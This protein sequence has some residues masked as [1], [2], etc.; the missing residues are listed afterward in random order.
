MDH[1]HPLVRG[2]IRHG[3]HPLLNMA[4]ANAI[5]VKDPAN[6]LKLDKAQST[7]RIDPL[8]ATVMSAFPCL[9]DKVAVFDVS[10]MIG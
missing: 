5:A 2:R 10:S 3:D 9:E 7:L 4:V 1:R 8:V 6:N